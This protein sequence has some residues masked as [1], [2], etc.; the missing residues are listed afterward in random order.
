M[1]CFLF[2]ENGNAACGGCGVC[3]AV[4]PRSLF[5]EGLVVSGAGNAVSR[6][7]QLLVL[8]ETASAAELQLIQG[9]TPPGMSHD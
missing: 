4:S 6:R 5:K 2:A 3:L 1:S 9:H 8:S 7:L